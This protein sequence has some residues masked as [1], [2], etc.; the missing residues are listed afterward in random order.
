MRG[1][2]Y[3]FATVMVA[4]L[5]TGCVRS[6]LAVSVNEDG[7]GTYSA[8]DL[9]YPRFVSTLVQRPFVDRV[10]LADT[11]RARVFQGA[12]DTWDRPLVALD[13]ELRRMVVAREGRALFRPA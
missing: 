8:I 13:T 1:L 9:V 7:S 11:T 10:S 5:A 6:D 3:L 4:I 2:R 12:A